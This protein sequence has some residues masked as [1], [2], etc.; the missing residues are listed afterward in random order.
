[1]NNYKLGALKIG[2][3]LSGAETFTNSPQKFE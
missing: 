2:V 3:Y 1:M